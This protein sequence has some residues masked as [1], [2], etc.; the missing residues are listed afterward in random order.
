[1]VE[2]KVQY[3]NSRVLCLYPTQYG[4]IERRGYRSGYRQVPRIQRSMELKA[5]TKIPPT[6]ISMC[7]QRSIVE[8]KV[9]M[10]NNNAFYFMCIQRS[11]VELKG[12]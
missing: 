12:N 7:I 9:H 11:M 8:L 10:V 1:M 4:G 6:T 2:L 5:L 3:G